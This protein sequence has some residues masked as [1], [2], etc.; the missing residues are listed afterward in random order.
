MTIPNGSVNAKLD[1][2]LVAI[3]TTREETARQNKLRDRR[4]QRSGIA[5]VAAFVVGI[6]GG[7]YAWSANGSANEA[8]DALK[9][10]Q[11]Q[12]QVAR[13]ASC[14]QSNRATQNTRD[15]LVGGI[16]IV[17][18]GPTATPEQVAALVQFKAD[19]KAATEKKLPLRDC[20]DAGI[21][22]FLGITTTTTENKP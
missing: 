21:A 1:Q 18:P 9:A 15:A 13:R 4:I 3:E 8:K 16:A 11:A 6:G 12:T 20:T 14:D 10:S 7:I 19:Y 17:Q 5:I 2:L 22:K